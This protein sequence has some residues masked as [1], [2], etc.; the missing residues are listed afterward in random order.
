MK[1]LRVMLVDDEIDFLDTLIKRMEKR[2]VAVKG[3]N[4]G[5]QALLLLDEGLVD[6][7][8]L[9]VKMPGMDGID[10]LKE[11]KRRH[12]LIEV[13]LLTGHAN[14]EVAIQGMEL[15]AFD[16]LIKPISIDEL[17]YKV[18]D[19]YEKSSIR[20]KKISNM[21]RVIKAGR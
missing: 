19:A 8:V 12:P 6:V 10:T 18:Q 20:K 16:Y 1:S 15:G 14:T 4:S 17:L 3:A 13:I 5:E 21:E 2:N 11:I 7:I 9:D